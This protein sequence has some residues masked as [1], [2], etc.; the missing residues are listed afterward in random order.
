MNALVIIDMQDAYFKSPGLVSRKRRLVNAINR[1]VAEHHQS[2]DLV[3]NI[4]TVHRR[5]KSTWTLNMLQDKQGFAFEDSKETRPIEGLELGGAHEIIKTRDSAFHGTD[6]LDRL[7]NDHV[8]A[9]TLAG[10]STHSCIF[11]T[12]AAAY[13]HNLTVTVAADAV[14]DEDEEMAAQALEY[15]RRE[16]R[17]EI[18]ATKW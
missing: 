9:I 16:Y 17:Q 4:R 7:R 14:G 8:T 15:L 10:V 2:G 12:A 5:D 3:F 18:T 6:L 1:L 11:H 13:A